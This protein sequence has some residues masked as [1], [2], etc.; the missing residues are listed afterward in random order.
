MPNVLTTGS[1]V[2]CGHLAGNPTGKVQ[3]DS[4]A[5]LKVKGDPVLL[6]SSIDGKSISNC[7]IV[8]ALDGSGNPIAMKCTQVSV[9]P[10]VPTL[11]PGTPPA[12][13]DGRSTKLKVGG[14]P[15]MLDT[16][17]GR[18]NGMNGMSKKQS[19]L[20]DMSGTAHQ[21]KLTAV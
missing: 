2:T 13:T 1:T 6:E 14:K 12:I 16:L 4:S 20:S 18:T 19:P 11:P 8:P 3:I 5:K 15:V 17:K 9:I 7:G 21:R 10:Q